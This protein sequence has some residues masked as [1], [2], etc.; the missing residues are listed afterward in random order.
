MAFAAMRVSFCAALFIFAA[1]GRGSYFCWR[2]VFLRGRVPG[3]PLA[4]LVQAGGRV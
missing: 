3:D 2:V 1:T 4:E